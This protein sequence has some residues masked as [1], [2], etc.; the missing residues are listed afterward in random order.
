MSSKQ[1][2][3]G[4]V[5]T[6]EELESLVEDDEP[7]AP[8][9]GVRPRW[10]RWRSC[11]KCLLVS[12]VF[13][14]FVLLC[15]AVLV[16]ILPVYLLRGNSIVDNCSLD[17]GDRFD[18]LPGFSTVN[19]SVCSHHGCCWQANSTVPCFY[20]RHSGYVVVGESQST[21]LGDRV[22]LERKTDEVGSPY[23]YDIQPLVV[24]I[25]YETESRLHIKVSI[26]TLV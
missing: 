26:S 2:L 6:S 21:S 14:V 16:V 11:K 20:S 8:A 15:L 18:C 3:Y 22:I 25:S 1:R 4:R 5:S 7:F 13:I 12:A 24:D 9:V 19:Q 10:P 17:A 23:G